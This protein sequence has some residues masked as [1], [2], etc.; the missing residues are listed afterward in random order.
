MTEESKS[1]K[2]RYINLQSV[3]S[4]ITTLVFFGVYIYIAS[5][6]TERTLLFGIIMLVLCLC[7]LLILQALNKYV[8]AR[9]VRAEE[10]EQHT[11]SDL[12]RGLLGRLGIPVAICNEAG[13]IIWHNVSFRK[14]AGAEDS[15]FGSDISSIADF[16]YRKITDAHE[17]ISG[18]KCSVG[19]GLYTVKSY[20]V[21]I[22]DRDYNVLI[23]TDITELE[24]AYAR[25]DEE[26]TQ[27]AH[28]VI[29]NLSELLQYT[30]EKSRS[31]STEIEGILS[32]WANSVGGVLKEYER[33]HFL[34]IFH[35]CY[36]A[37]FTKDKFDVIN[38]IREVRIGD[39]SLPVTVSIGVSA[40][41]G[42]L[43]EK[44]KAAHTALDMALQRGGD[45]VAVKYENEMVFYGGKTKTVQK[46]TKVRARVFVNELI[47]HISMSTNV[48]IM[49]HAGADLDSLGACVGIAKLVQ[50]C[51][52]DANIVADSD[53]PNNERF[54]KKLSSMP[55]Y[56]GIVIDRAEAL[57]L[58]HSS[59]LL[60][61]VDVNN[62]EK[63]ESPDLFASVN[64]AV[65]IDHHIK[66]DEYEVA[67]SYIEPSASSTCE[68]VSELLEQALPTGSLTKDEADM[69]LSGILL[70][71]KQF[72]R[73]TGSR[74]F[75][76]AQYL[77]NQG[78]VPAD[79]QNYYKSSVN[80][81]T[82]EARFEGKIKTYKENL[83]I[84]VND[85][86][87]NTAADRI[88]AAKVA[89]KLLELDN[90]LASFAVLSI[91]KDVYISARSTGK[92]NVQKIM[93]Y[94]GGGGS[95]DSSATKLENV[96]LESGVLKL[97]E[98]IDKYYRED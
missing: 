19:D 40:I 9:K 97:K 20:D 75:G 30:P 63:F 29:D 2:K 46:R 43:D 74:T 91:E 38:K 42:R 79:A 57:E 55:G 60:V 47:H 41:D 16:D 54:F 76:A 22:E 85:Y 88:I 59:S 32:E 66:N 62:R 83:A 73:N 17:N 94:M 1:K 8:F 5:F 26:S 10:E 49:G 90:V 67:F 48:L 71:T 12:A 36:L 18:G 84:A 7:T 6:V 86:N 4:V 23:F 21:K 81:F 53:D 52:V 27:V 24:H 69:L 61:V 14:A 28:I 3:V 37:D 80:E 35:N 68:I 96:D 25:I 93:E 58:N 77:R 11:V 33:D 70:D 65:V 31:A 92:I 13:K 39:G 45:Q 56:E 78:A 51:G 15:Y 34:F 72:T 98:A 95:Y 82:R 87:D 50:F 89:D 64:K 44:E